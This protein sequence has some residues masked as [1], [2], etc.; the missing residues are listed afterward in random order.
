MDYSNAID[1][2]KSR[3]SDNNGSLKVITLGGRSYFNIFPDKETDQF[4]LC[5]TN[6]KGSKKRIA[7]SN[8]DAVII[9]ISE[10]ESQNG[11]GNF[12]SSDFTDPQ[13]VNKESAGRIFNP[14][15]A[16]LV[17]YLSLK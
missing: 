14:Y 3:L 12:R 5:I 17:R 4:M 2:I 11:E 9:R 7:R 15:V 16:A 1:L 10:L 8:W 13:W 6:S